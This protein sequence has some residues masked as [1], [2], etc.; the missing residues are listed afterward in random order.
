[1]NKAQESNFW[2]IIQIIMVNPPAL[3][4]VVKQMISS[5]YFKTLATAQF[6]IIL[7]LQACVGLSV[8]WHHWPSNLTKFGDPESTEILCRQHST[9]AYLFCSFFSFSFLFAMVLRQIISKKL[10]T[11]ASLSATLNYLHTTSQ[12]MEIFDN[13]YCTKHLTFWILQDPSCRNVLILPN[14]GVC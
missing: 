13:H 14:L 12:W 5:R 6:C 4:L 2:Y 9:V 3:L 8:S 1:M 10:V 7:Q 11:N